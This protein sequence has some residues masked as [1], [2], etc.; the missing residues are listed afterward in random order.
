MTKVFK[1]SRRELS[2]ISKHTYSWY[3]LIDKYLLETVSDGTDCDRLDGYNPR[4]LWIRINQALIENYL[5]RANKTEINVRPRNISLRANRILM[6]RKCSVAYILCNHFWHR[7]ICERK[8]FNMT[9]FLD[10]LFLSFTSAHRFG[11]QTGMGLVWIWLHW[12]K[13][14]GDLI[15]WDYLGFLREIRVKQPSFCPSDSKFDLS[16]DHK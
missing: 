7:S 11:R 13:H 15:L 16:S 8:R 4:L 10:S 1:S 2:D 9:D 5:N 6:I 3:A 14:F 12:P